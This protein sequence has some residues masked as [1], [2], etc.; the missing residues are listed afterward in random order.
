MSTATTENRTTATAETKR[1]GRPR[2]NVDATAPKV[3]DATTKAKAQEKFDMQVT[4][5]QP[6]RQAIG[7]M[8]PTAMKGLLFISNFE[9]KDPDSPAPDKHGYQREVIE[10]RIP[11]MA[12][13][14][15]A[16]GDTPRTPPMTLSV[17][18][19]DKAKI[20]KFMDLFNKG[21]KYGLIKEFGSKVISVV[22]GQHRF[23]AFVRANEVND[24]YN[25][26]VPVTIHFG[27][28]FTDEARLFDTINS[29]QRKLPKAL[30]ESTKA[31]V[32]EVGEP[33]YQ[34]RIRLIA[35]QLTHDEDSVWYGRVDRTGAARGAEKQERPISYEGLRRATSNM[36]PLTLLDQMDTE[37]RDPVEVA[38]QYWKYVAESSPEAWNNE[39]AEVIE[40]GEPK[41]KI[42]AY[43]LREVV[44]LAATAK[45]GQDIIKSAMEHEDFDARMKA[46]TERL[47]AVDW[48][49]SEDNPWMSRS[50]AGF[51]G[52]PGLYAVLHGWVYSG[53]RPPGA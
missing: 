22:D 46:L 31:D 13:N 29:T 7:Y 21:D 16:E 53:K 14:F 11:G 45:L 42:V 34:Q 3:S 5:L 44:G 19:D 17:R 26:R 51:A 35:S 27:L 6:Y 50:Q 41:E 32:T 43:R 37:E 38:K 49:K 12:R 33:S 52:Q 25:P 24:T 10:S 4:V 23:L 48:I 9:G 36:F 40:D 39:P 47:G 30:I 28:T 18:T 8:T 20:D 2:K 15:L 1:R